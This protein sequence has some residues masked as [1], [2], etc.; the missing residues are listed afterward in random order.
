MNNSTL[1]LLKILS[2]SKE[3]ADRFDSK[4]R[5]RLDEV[6]ENIFKMNDSLLR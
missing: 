6:D 2:A 3:M 1:K 5:E 4:V